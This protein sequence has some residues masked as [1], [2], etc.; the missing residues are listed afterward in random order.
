MKPDRNMAFSAKDLP[1]HIG[2]DNLLWKVPVGGHWQMMPTIVGDRVLTQADGQT[3]MCLNRQNG[4]I[5]WSSGKISKKGSGNAPV[6]FGN[7]VFIGM[8]NQDTTFDYYCFD[9]NGQEDGDQGEKD[10]KQGKEFADVIWQIKIVASPHDYYACTP[11]II[12]GKLWFSTCHSPTSYSG[13]KKTLMYEYPWRPNM[14]VI[15]PENGRIL[16]RDNKDIKHN[17][18]QWSSISY[19]E[20][21]GKRMVFWGDGDGYA[22]AFKIPQSFNNG[23]TPDTLETYWRQDCTPKEFSNDY[24]AR[25]NWKKGQGRRTEII[26]TPVPYEGRLYIVTG[27]DY[28]YAIEKTSKGIGSSG[29][30]Y[31]LAALSCL[32]PATGKIIWQNR[33]ST[34]ISM[35]TPSISDGLLYL[36]DCAGFLRCFDIT[37]GKQLWEHDLL[38]MSWTA[39]AVLADG[40]IYVSN[41]SKKFWVFKHSRTKVMISENDLTD[42]DISSP[43][44]VDGMMII[45]FKKSINA[46]GGPEYMKKFAKKGAMK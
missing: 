16:A 12:D 5:L 1:D 39:S 30:S 10:I 9:L 44:L 37:D 23:K 4:K 45:V 35:G 24:Y 46:Y 43:A 19:G 13:D 34:H 2:D 17:H 8:G 36:T 29:R 21:S 28:V 15:D 42:G 18:G 38:G 32:D 26:G 22:W 33:N 14:L 40:K 7:R 25:V 3:L 27:R 20:A 11:L 6:V 41:N 31:E